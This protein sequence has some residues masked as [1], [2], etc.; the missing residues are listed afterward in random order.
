M[1]QHDILQILYNDN[2]FTTS[3]SE[4]QI[5]MV[6]SNGNNINLEKSYYHIFSNYEQIWIRVSL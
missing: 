1:T 5:V 4:E 2:W 6:D 3:K